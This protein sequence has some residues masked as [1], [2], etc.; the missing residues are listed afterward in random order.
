MKNFFHRYLKMVV[1][2]S[3]IIGI[4]TLTPIQTIAQWGALGNYPTN[5]IFTSSIQCSAIDAS[6]NIYI[7]G[8]FRNGNSKAY[9]AKWNGNSWVELG[10]LNT[11]T[12]NNSINSMTI[13]AIGNIYI[14]GNF[15]NGNSKRYVAKWDGG[16]WS[17]LGGT[18][19]STFNNT[20]YAMTKDASGNIYVGGQFTNTYPNN[21]IAK[22]N[23]VSWSQLGVNNYFGNASGIR[24][25]TTDANGNIYAGGY[26]VNSNGK[27]K[28]SKWDGNSWSELGGTNTSTF[29]NTLGNITVI[30]S[31]CADISGNIY[32]AGNFNNTSGKQYVAKWNGTTW[33]ELGGTNKSTFNNDI[34]ILIPD[35][36]GNVFT[37]GNFK[38]TIGNQYISKWNGSSWSELGGT[39]SSA[40]NSRIYCIIFDKNTNLY[41]GGLFSNANNNQYLAKWNGSA[42]SE[43]GG[44]N[45]ETFNNG[46]V[47]ITKD[48]N[49]NFYTGG[50]FTNLNS[51]KSIAKWNGSEWAEVGGKNTSTFAIGISTLTTDANGN[52]YAGGSFT[53]SNGKVYVAKWNGTNWSELGGTNTSPFNSG[54]SSIITDA[55]GNIYVSGYFTNASGNYYVAKWDGSTWSELGGPNNTIFNSGVLCMCIDKIGNIYA[56]GTHYNSSGKRIVAKWNGSTWSELG[57]TNTSTFNDYIY[58]ITTDLKGN[59]YAAG[60]FTNTSSNNY[61]AKWNGISWSELGGTNKSTIN[62][63][64]NTIAC[65]ANSN[66]Y[67]AGSFTNSN[68]KNYVANWNGSVWSELGGTGSTTFGA[69]IYSLITDALG[70]VYAGGEFTLTSVGYPT[71]YIAKYTTSIAP[72]ITGF[73]P[74]TGVTGATVTIT[75]TNFT[76]ATAVSFGG[77]AATSFTVVN[78]TNITAVVGSGAS[79]SVS[80]TTGSG[81]ATKGGFTY[82]VATNSTTNMSICNT[83]LPYLWNGSSY[84]LAGSYTKTLVNAKGCDSVATLNLTTKATSTSTTNVSICSTALPYVWNGGSYSS[85]GSYTKTFANAKGCDSVATLNLTIKATSTSTTNVSICSTALPY[86]WNGGSYSSAGSYTKTLANAKGCDSIATLQL[87]VTNASTPTVSINASLASICSGTS[88]VFTATPINGGTSPIYQW[89]KNG[90]TVGSN[91]NTYSSA[92]LLNG[93]SISC[94]LTVNNTCQTV[95]TGI[96][97]V[98]GISVTHTWTGSVSSSWMNAAN[99]CGNI[100]PASGAD[101]VI[102][103]LSS[104]NYPLLLS[105]TIVGNLSMASGA[106]LSLGGN[107]LTINGTTIGT[108]M[109]KGSSASSLIINSTS[110]PTLYFNPASNDSLLGSLT[111]SGTGGAKLGSGLGI[112]VLLQLNAGNLNL[113]GNCL[114]LKSTSITNTAMVGT[115]GSTASVTGNITIERYIPIGYK[116]YRQL[117][118][119]GVYNAGSIFNNWQEA[120]IR[121]KGLGTYIIGNKSTIA[122]FNSITGLDNSTNGATGLYIFSNASASWT[123][124]AN[125]KTTMMNPYTGYHVSIFGDRTSNLYASNFDS[126]AAMTS[127]TTL[128]ASG[129]L[130]TGTVTYNTTGVAGNYNSTANPLA[131]S[132]NAA[133]FIA[134]PYPSIID[135]ESLASVGLTSSYSYFDPT[136]LVSSSYQVY[137][138]YNS[139]THTNSS[140]TI[141]KMNRYIQPGQAFWVQNNSLNM[142]RQLIITENNKVTDANKLTAIFR[143]DNP[144][145]RLAIS[146]WKDVSGIGNATIDGAVAVFDHRFTQQY[147]KEDARKLKNPK[148]NLAITESGDDLAIDGLGLPIVQDVIH[149]KLSQ[150]A[151]STTYRLRIDATLFNADGLQAFLQDDYL[152]HQMAITNDAT[153]YA[154]T[155]TGV[156]TEMGNR[157]HIVFEQ[158]PTSVPIAA[159]IKAGQINLYPNPTNGKTTTVRLSDMAKG[160]YKIAVYN[161]LGQQLLLQTIWHDGGT[162]NYPITLPMQKGLLN[163]KVMDSNGKQWFQMP[164]LGE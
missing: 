138:A 55:S 108:G 128:R 42:L 68:T 57:G 10:G 77:A 12:F 97:N 164:L 63:R 147:G 60:G 146:L 69:V 1:V 118:A 46:I 149:L 134:N 104:N 30:N 129:Q 33:S 15:T 7:A 37:A 119:G 84:S 145:N 22:W 50:S 19:S 78:S 6:E 153:I 72:S 91:T 67:A 66:V 39:N 32:A 133:S 136:Y 58:S 36:I 142:S 96:S 98:I 94:V 90:A 151:A 105:N 117:S 155:S 13:D 80:V 130:I 16:S 85:A 9:V 3:F 41:A 89:K 112:T 107:Q 53:N 102:P 35:A 88:V 56:A 135:W 123:A 103:T 5:G 163:M 47:S 26:I 157:F 38:N 71:R 124:I 73:T 159:G 11:S 87:A 83:A 40:F 52:L 54:I 160:H 61:I 75:G 114:T 28:V 125:T 144:V 141:S 100:V 25:L 154:F 45:W 51:K 2:L 162:F 150:L 132:A 76:G 158:K 121:T 31:I 115:V 111:I 122:G 43:V 62:S 139:T 93:D 156:A 21:Y 140:P 29:K 81:T 106:T 92:T 74:T 79:G 65:D 70:S 161:V 8:D 4:T 14:S 120:G 44:I 109:F 152:H 101:V 49:G 82:C 148:E 127:A 59:L 137:V 18:N 24:C 48:A 23:G 143:N 110:T 20:I 95:A 27:S 113:N 126:T 17:E 64:I 116:A 34:N 86:A 131:S 99:W